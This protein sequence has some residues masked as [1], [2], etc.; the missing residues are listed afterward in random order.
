MS[1]QLRQY[2]TDIIDQTRTLMMQGHRSILIQSPT[3]SGKTALTAS[4]LGTAAS[5]GMDS[6]FLVHRR[7]LIKQSVKAFSNVGIRHGVI[8]NGFQ[9]DLRHCIQIGSVQTLAN[10]INRTRRPKLIVWDEAHH[11]AA[12]SWSKIFAAYP[13]AFHIGL[14]AT[15]E[16][17]DGKGLK[18]FFNRLILG[19]KVEWLIE[20][21]FLSK[22]RLFAPGGIDISGLHI[23]MGDYVKSELNSVADRPS[24]TGDAIKHYLKHAR[25]RRAVVF[26]VS[27]EHSKHVAAQ[28]NEAGITASHV[29]G[30]TDSQERDKAIQKFETGETLIL[31]NVELFGE[32]FD[33]PAIEVAILL[34][35]TQ[36]LGLHL[37]Q[38]GRSLRPS[39]GKEFAI[40]LDHAGNTQRHGLPDQERE[41][42][43]EGRVKKKGDAEATV[44]VKICPKCFAATFAGATA[45]KYCGFVYQIQSREVDFKEGDLEEVDVEAIKRRKKQEQGQAQTYEE[46]VALGRERRYDYPE[47][48]ASNLIKFRQA[49][50]LGYR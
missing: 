49:K 7:E 43:L 31:C 46:L 14:T 30:T 28:F 40:I 5:K 38:I 24:I 36:S 10:R 33:L 50:R 21:G 45:C 18:K 23:R 1:F 4:M 44:N 37:Q 17:L 20:N 11:I 32:G 34:R 48:W 8:A 41:W 3:G 12:G 26:C 16:R 35:P 27:V 22:Y 13:D 9:E 2:Q 15:P 29:D 6:W 19:P 25:G 39:P 42:S 47:K